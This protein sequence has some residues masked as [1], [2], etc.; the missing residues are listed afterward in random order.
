MSTARSW[1]WALAIATFAF[2]LSPLVVTDFAGFDPEQYPIPQR[3]PPV[4]PAGWAFAIW[5]PIY[6]WLLVS[7][8]FGLLRRAETEAWAAFRPAL[9]VSLAIGAIWLWVA[10]RSPVWATILIWVMLVAA[11]LAHLATPRREPI[12]AAAP[13]GL[14]AG[15]LTA[16]AFVSLGLLAAGYGLVDARPAAW[17]AIAGAAITA[18]AVG[19]RRREPA[20]FAAIAWAL[21][22]IAWANG[23]GRLGIAA[24]FLALC[25]AI[26]SVLTARRRI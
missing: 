15:W 3:D 19:L 12:F 4:Q 7:A 18:L 6:L 26:L 1:A 20:Y 21:A 11:L 9:T 8:A 2:A 25:A 14:Y 17:A 13:V 10:M 24:L 5:G 23:S 16:A 22:G